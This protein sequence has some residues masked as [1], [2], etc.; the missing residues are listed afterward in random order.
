M[1]LCTETV[2]RIVYV[3]ILYLHSAKSKESESQAQTQHISVK[4]RSI[5]QSIHSFKNNIKCTSFF[6]QT[7]RRIWGFSRFLLKVLN[8][9]LDI[10]A[11]TAVQK[12]VHLQFL[13]GIWYSAIQSVREIE[14]SYCSK[15]KVV[16]GVTWHV[17]AKSFY[18]DMTSCYLP[19]CCSLWTHSGFHFW[20]TKNWR[21]NRDHS[22]KWYWYAFF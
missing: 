10:L 15:H 5:E 18:L 4:L 7:A 19:G 2:E 12:M 8:I 20:R 9:I 17:P 22:W 1:A 13:Y 14:Y 21:P 6:N 11:N 16:L 3:I